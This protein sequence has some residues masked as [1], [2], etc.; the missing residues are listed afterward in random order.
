MVFT[1]VN[2]QYDMHAM[3]WKFEES[4]LNLDI[5]PDHMTRI[6]SINNHLPGSLPLSPSAGVKSYAPDKSFQIT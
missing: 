3:M 6:N 1:L 4:K 2:S 5:T